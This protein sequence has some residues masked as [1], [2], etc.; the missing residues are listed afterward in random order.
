MKYQK[1]IEKI[2]YKDIWISKM[3]YPSIGSKITI[4]I[5]GR[6]WKAGDLNNHFSVDLLISLKFQH[7]AFNW[8]GW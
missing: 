3:S 8:T 4:R 1:N 2:I 5:Q 6:N 7:S